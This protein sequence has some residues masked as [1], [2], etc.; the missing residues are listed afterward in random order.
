MSPAQ[1]NWGI[2]IG[3]DQYDVAEACLK[4]AVNDAL[5]MRRWLLDPAGGGVPERQLF[6]L[7]SAAPNRNPGGIT[8]LPATRANAITVIERVLARSGGQGDRFFFHFSGHGLSARINATNQ[9]GIAFADFNELLTDNSLT[10]QALFDLFQSTQFKEQFFFIDGCRNAP[11]GSDRILGSY[12][13]PR[14]AQPP[15]SP[16]FGMYATAPMLKALEVDERGAFTQALLDGLA[17]QGSAKRWDSDIAS[18]LIRWSA[19]FSYVHK[20]VTARKLNAGDLI[21]TPRRFGETNGEDPILASK[22]EKE[23]GQ[24]RLNVKL[25]PADALQ[26]SSVLVRDLYGAGKREPKPIKGLPVCFD[27]APRSY[28]VDVEADGWERQGNVRSVDLYEPCDVELILTPS[29]APPLANIIVQGIETYRHELWSDDVES[30]DGDEDRSPMRAPSSS[31]KPSLLEVYSNDHLATL[32]IADEAGRVIK[33]GRLAVKLT[34]CPP[35]FYRARL[36]SP[37]GGATEELVQVGEY[38]TLKVEA[39]APPLTSPVLRQLVASVGFSSGMDGTVSVSE[40]VG[41]SA[42]L[43]LS[44]VLALA[45]AAAAETGSPYG[46]RLRAVGIPAFSAVT[47]AGCGVQIVVGC[48]DGTDWIARLRISVGALDDASDATRSLDRLPN[49]PEIAAAS[50]A[51]EPGSCQLRLQDVGQ[52]ASQLTCPLVV[53]PDRMTLLVITRDRESRIEIHLYM[54][55]VA[56]PQAHGMPFRDVQFADSNFA[57]LRRV[58]LMQRAAANGRVSPTA[59]EIELLLWDKWRDPVAGC[60]G[61]YLGLR[62]GDA[63]EKLDEASRNLVASF[64]LLPDSHILRG[65]VLE[66]IGRPGAATSYAAALDAGLPLF[67]DGVALLETAVTRL[68]L[69]HARLSVLKALAARPPADPLWS[70]TLR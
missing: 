36:L 67:R 70:A 69:Q 68:E 31:V 37:E 18:Y 35:G 7:L 21:Q 61:V 43:Q 66:K 56:G 4:G 9:S 14:P 27:L 51:R 8:S 30:S 28:G 24:V 3:I 34:P 11:F 44:T 57:A 45:A 63:P 23:F 49:T 17:G 32:E 60:L 20:A 48:D 13:K 38:Q 25:A 15:V 12:P 47:G 59:P 46:Q 26:H 41:P 29:P 39:S 16:Q 42:S 5:A 6:L 19:L 54:P 22:S 2:V 62:R 1:D 10:V 52:A 33:T 53:L 64:G 50:F 65:T 40:S 55:A 58:E